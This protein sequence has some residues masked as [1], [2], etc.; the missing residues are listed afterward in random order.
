MFTTP[1]LKEGLMSGKGKNVEMAGLGG[2][3]GGILGNLGGG[4][5][6]R[7]S[8]LELATK[9]VIVKEKIIERALTNKFATI[10]RRRTTLQNRKQDAQDRADDKDGID[11]KDP[12]EKF[13]KAYPQTYK[14]F[15]EDKSL[16]RAWFT[17]EALYS[18]C[19]F[20]QAI[21]YL[22][23]YY[24]FL[25]YFTNCLL[26]CYKESEQPVYMARIHGFLGS[27]KIVLWN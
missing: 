1:N 15:M 20:F 22:I 25:G 10:K 11:G 23:I 14:E 17:S 5:G 13:C 16:I 9:N 3:G 18:S 4:R 26:F 21:L 7:L 6:K 27:N 24:F 19:E 8:V 12:Y 2:L